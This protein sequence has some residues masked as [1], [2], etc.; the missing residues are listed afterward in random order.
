ML[1]KAAQ[2]R[3]SVEEN[4]YEAEFLFFQGVSRYRKGRLKSLRRDLDN[5]TRP[6]QGAAYVLKRNQ[7]DERTIDF[8]LLS[9]GKQ[10]HHCLDL[11]KDDFF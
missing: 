8:F 4:R 2:T 5:R 6:T 11:N 9:G 1:T 7:K 10:S 3:A